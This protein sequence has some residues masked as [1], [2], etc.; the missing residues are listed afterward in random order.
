MSCKGK[1]C[2]S[3]C[4]YHTL[5]Y[6]EDVTK[7]TPDCNDVL[8]YNC[9][10]GHWAP[11]KIDLSDLEGIDIDYDSLVTGDSYYF[12]WDGEK[13][14]VVSATFAGLNDVD[15][16][17][18]SSGDLVKWDGTNWVPYSVEDLSDDVLPNLVEELS[19][20]DLSNVS[21]ADSAA[22]GSVL[23]KTA[24]D[25]GATSPSS[26]ASSIYLTDLGDVSITGASSGEVLRFNGTAWADATLSTN[27]I[28]NGSGVSGSTATNALNNL[29]SRV[30]TLESAPGGGGGAAENIQMLRGKIGLAFPAGGAGWSAIRLGPGN[31]Q[32]T[33]TVTVPS[34]VT[35]L[36]T[37]GTSVT[38]ALFGYSF[39]PGGTP[40]SGGFTVA[41][42]RWS[43]ATW[44]LDDV[45][46]SFLAVWGV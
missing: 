45:G 20:D 30:S 8:I 43:G 11:G 31:Y 9:V 28:S 32:V 42:Y 36:L 44:D 18:L 13:F 25:W 5:Q 12:Q 34:D 41:V 39:S 15:L 23:V 24:G 35:L 16:T 26:F 27:D 1:K 2:T 22:T 14:V 46:L 7:D 10:S 3:C 38:G 4:C 21:T 37:P 19:L 33:W 40:S 6:H 29:N 17:G